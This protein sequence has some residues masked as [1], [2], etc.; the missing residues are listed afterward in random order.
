M[1]STRP[2]WTVTLKLPPSNKPHFRRMHRRQIQPVH[3][4][5]QHHRLRP[6][7]LQPSLRSPR[8][9]PR[10]CPTSIGSGIRIS[11][12]RNRETF[13]TVFCRTRPICRD[14]LPTK[15]ETCVHRM[16]RRPHWRRSIYL[17]PAIARTQTVIV[18]RWMSAMG[19]S[20]QLRHRYRHRVLCSG[21]HVY[22]SPSRHRRPQ[23]TRQRN[24]IRIRLRNC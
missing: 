24:E 3:C 18:I 17:R 5:R 10:P 11:F 6:L 15:H 2:P 9:A 13:T 12:I 23:Q 20:R 22:T 16:N 7:L 4:P 19:N 21:L 1:H 8:T 14:F